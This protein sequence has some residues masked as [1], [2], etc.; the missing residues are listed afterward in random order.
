M[1][2]KGILMSILVIGVVAMAAGAG[3]F[4]QFSDTETSE[5]NTFTAGTLDLGLANTEGTDPTGS[6]SATW[7]E[8]NWAPGNTVTGTLYVNNE[9][10]IAAESVVVTFSRTITEGTPETV[11][12]GT[13]TLDDVQVTKM[14]YDEVNI[15]DDVTAIV[16][17]GASPL[18][19]GELN[20]ESIDLEDDEED[21]HAADTEKALVMTFLLPSTADN[22][23]QGDTLDLTL[24]FTAS[25]DE[26]SPDHDDTLAPDL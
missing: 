26:K 17:D 11:D 9:G 18:T 21:V 6:T 5:G 23:V 24:A 2:S 13:S 15:L 16:G 14:T 3:T 7:T 20:G 25:Q 22:G 1:I 12:P 10:S 8:N 4:A 19:I